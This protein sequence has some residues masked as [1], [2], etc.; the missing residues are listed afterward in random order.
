MKQ[1]IA[2]FYFLLVHCE[3]DW[4]LLLCINIAAFNLKEF[5]FTLE[6]K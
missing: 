4:N 5:I 1:W 2:T 3:H 6:N